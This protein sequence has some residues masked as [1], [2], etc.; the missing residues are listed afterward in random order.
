MSSVDEIRETVRKHDEQIKLK[1]QCEVLTDL[2]LK[3]WWNEQQRIIL[4][5]WLNSRKEKLNGRG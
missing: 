5:E 4:Q 3:D 1:A 2:L